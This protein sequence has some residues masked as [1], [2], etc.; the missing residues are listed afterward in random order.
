MNLI[1]NQQDQDR[2]R[3]KLYQN[4]KAIKL[5][6]RY[7]SSWSPFGDIWAVSNNSWT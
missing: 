4:Y 6:Y 2:V 1:K 3:D 7:F 5:A